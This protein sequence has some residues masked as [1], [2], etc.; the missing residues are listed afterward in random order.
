MSSTYRP[1]GNENEETEEGVDGGN[2]TE[3]INGR[4]ARKGKRQSRE[5]KKRRD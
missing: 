3:E 1:S 5:R 2:T 4:E